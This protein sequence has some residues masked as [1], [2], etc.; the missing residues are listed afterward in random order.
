[1]IFEFFCKRLGRHISTWVPGQCQT[2]CRALHQLISSQHSGSSMTL[3]SSTRPLL[4]VPRTRTA[5]GSRA[6]SSAVPAIWNNLPTS[7][8]EANSLPV[9]R[10]RL[11]T[12]L[13]TVAFKNSGQRLCICTLCVVLWR[14]ISLFLT[15]TLIG[16]EYM[17]L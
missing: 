12:H 1:M 10:R 16:I 4:Q 17:L 14:F 13:F 15:L 9:F 8:T 2:C 11:K 7:V 6:F 3:H 5:Y